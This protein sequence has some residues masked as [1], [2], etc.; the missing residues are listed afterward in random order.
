MTRT[1]IGEYKVTRRLEEA[2]EV[3]LARSPRGYNCRIRLLDRPDDDEAW[4]LARRSA[5]LCTN[6]DHPAV[7][8]V[9]DAFEDE[10]KLAL[11][12]DP[13]DG[14]TLDKLLQKL[15]SSGQALDLEAVWYVGHQLAGA[16][17]QAHTTG[18][19]DGD[20]VAVCHGHLTPRAVVVAWNGF[21]R[22]DGFGLAPLVSAGAVPVEATFRAPEEA[23]GGRITP[24]GDCY[25]LGMLIWTLL[26]WEIWFQIF[27]DRG[28][29]RP[30]VNGSRQTVNESTLQPVEQLS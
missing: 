28:A 7:G 12:F 26:T 5:E 6:L 1:S 4:D 25:A 29:I 15:Q 18:D 19:D 8:K 21:V 3:Y 23:G 11:V 27:V 22:L 13:I 16:M 24:R 10:D 17:A 14:D 9:I 20:I 30:P 2:D